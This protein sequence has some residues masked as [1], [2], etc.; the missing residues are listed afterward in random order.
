[1]TPLYDWDS[2]SEEAAYRAAAAEGRRMVG[3]E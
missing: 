1:M 3:L 2:P